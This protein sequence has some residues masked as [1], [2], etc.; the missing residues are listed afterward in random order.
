[1]KKYFYIIIRNYGLIS[2]LQDNYWNTEDFDNK[3][4]VME[5]LKET[6]QNKKN[7]KSPCEDNLNSEL[8]KYAGDLFH[9]RL[10]FL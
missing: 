10:L 6:L 1:M 8:Y 4:K 3:I 5:E 9:E 2:S 7:G